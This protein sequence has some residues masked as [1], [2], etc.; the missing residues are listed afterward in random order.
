MSTLE[1]A[2]A[3]SESAAQRRAHLSA[4][5]L[6]A[7]LMRLSA[8]LARGAFRLRARL[9]PRGGAYDHALA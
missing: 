7:G 5:A 6:L 8:C 2:R 9:D 1:L 3:A 4:R